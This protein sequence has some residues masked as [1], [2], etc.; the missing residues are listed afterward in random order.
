MTK[1]TVVPTRKMPFGVYIRRNWPLYVLVMPAIIIAL[2]FSY[3][4][5]Y[6][7]QIAFR[8]FT[9]K[10][11]F[12]NSKWV[13]LKHFERFFATP[14][15]KSLILNTIRIIPLIKYVDNFF[16]QEDDW[17]IQTLYGPVGYNLYIDDNGV[18]QYIDTPSGMAY[19]NF[20]WTH[21]YQFF[22]LWTGDITAQK[23]TLNKNQTWKAKIDKE[24]GYIEATAT[25]S[26][27]PTLSFTEDE[28][29][30]LTFIQVTLDSTIR[31][32]RGEAIVG[33]KDIDATWD[34]YV[35]NI[36]E[37]GMDRVV[38]IYND[39]YARMVELTK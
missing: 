10:A 29:D 6:G 5:M 7:V 1:P 20:R 24:Q 3:Y 38:E 39:A 9:V 13:G 28:L 14:N 11:G 12:W 26:A 31:Q 18:Y 32:Y 17:G 21:S 2:L 15:A 27:S 8:N 30:E 36:Q 23:L 35:A 25:N 16:N 34:S 22:P 33:V 19:Q 4:P 37:L